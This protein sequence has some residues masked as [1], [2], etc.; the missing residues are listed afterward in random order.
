MS[1]A[2]LPPGVDA[3]ALPGIEH[4]A[5]LRAVGAVQL[6]GGIER[7]ARRAGEACARVEVVDER[8]VPD[9][10]HVLATELVGHAHCS[11]A[12]H[13]R[14][15]VRLE[16]GILGQLVDVAEAWVL[17][18]ADRVAGRARREHVLADLPVVG[19]GERREHVGPRFVD[20]ALLALVTQVHLGID[21]GM[22]RLVH[23]HVE[24]SAERREQFPVAVTQV[25]AL[26]E[27]VPVR[28]G[29][30]GRAV[31]VRRMHH[32]ADRTALVVPAVATERVAQEVV[33]LQ[34]MLVRGR[35]HRIAAGEQLRAGYRLLDAARHVPDLDA[36]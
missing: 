13:A 4:G 26:G 14:V 27:V 10:T 11:E 22:R 2:G 21:D 32:D 29:H 25:H 16:H 18:V 33:D 24:R 35:D 5:D 31:L 8:R 23:E 19:I 34:R 20:A 30:V 17:E 7:R 9:P 1:A 15:V 3:D 28:V 12:R 6:G 36:R